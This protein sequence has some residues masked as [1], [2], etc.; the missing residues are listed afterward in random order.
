MTVTL[1]ELKILAL[2]CQATGA[3]PDK[4][5]LLEI[6]WI[7]VRASA[8]AAWEISPV[9]AY[10][11]RLQKET[12]IPGP[13]KRVTGISDI[14]LTAALAAERVWQ[15]LIKT[16]K[17]VAAENQSAVCPTVIH[18]ARFE[19]PFLRELHLKND[20]HSPFPFLIICT[21]AIAARLLPDLPRRGIRAL[22]GY[23]GHSMPELKRSAD[24]AVATVAVWQQM[25]QL[26]K[27][28]CN[29]QTLPQLTD[30]LTATHPPNRT[31]RKF[32]MN[33]ATRRSLPDKP[34]IYR[35]RR[36]NGDLLYIGKA[37]SLRQR[38]NSYFRRSA[39][40]PEHILEMLTQAFDLDF[41]LA[42]SSLEAAILESDEI[43]RH[44]P[45]YNIALSRR[46]RSL[47]FCT[48]DF[49][50]RSTVPGRHYPIGPLS[51]GKLIDALSAFGAW[52]R[53]GVRMADDVL[54]CLGHTLLAVSPAYAPEIQALKAGLDLFHQKHHRRL[55]KQSP[56]RVLTA[57]GA[58]LWRERLA[59]LAHA[60]TGEL[61][62]DGNAELEQ[63]QNES[64]EAFEW[65][66]EAVATA[67]EDMLMHA[68][69]MIRRARWFCLLSE[70]AL[71]WASADLPQGFKYLV[72]FEKGD[73]RY[74]DDWHPGRETPIPPGFARS[75]RCR[76]KNLD[77]TTCDRLRV[78]TTEMRR[79]ISEGRRIE[80]RLG[81]K[82][83]ID[84]QHLKKALQWV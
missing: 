32:P 3:N 56:L 76:Q 25:V 11:I 1:S 75:F 65:T 77:L 52:V 46:Q 59:N 20:P 51:A 84:R 45:P 82:V 73:I 18:Y 72:V 9:Q 64:D 54:L 17:A 12:E 78:A 31:N 28:H 57:L 60:A 55:K 79:L 29:V 13:V 24:H 26:L 2:D 10:L 35:L 49:S 34:G 80:L 61:T 6:G 14:S 37:K 81:P 67:V 68:A 47:V 23:F 50:G 69:H 62:E 38:V 39:A 74:R 5:H 36:N 7:Q 8:P 27:T 40:H 30:W 22:A 66:P 15:H 48:K 43:K 63:E 58:Q 70:S 21:H 53:S 4:G 33:P 16:A 41:S 44:S 83:A 71:V 42:A 19:E